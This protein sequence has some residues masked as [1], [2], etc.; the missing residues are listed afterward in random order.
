MHDDLARVL[1]GVKC[2]V[3]PAMGHTDRI[4]ACNQKLSMRRSE[5]AKN[6]LAGK[7]ISPTVL[8]LMV[9]VKPDQ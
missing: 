5:A 2:K 9:K 3:I 4:G 1:E 7:G 6:Y 8:M